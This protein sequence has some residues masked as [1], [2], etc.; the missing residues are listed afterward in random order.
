MI[1]V[2]AHNNASNGIVYIIDDEAEVRDA[3]KFLF[4][5]VHL[6]VETFSTAEQFLKANPVKVKA[7]VLVDVRLPGMGGIDLLEWLNGHEDRIPI[8]MMT[9]FGDIATALTA[10]KAGAKDFIVKPFNPQ[11]LLESVNRYLNDTSEF[12]NHSFADVDSRYDTLTPREHQ[13]LD[14]IYEGKLNKQ[15]A[16]ELSISLST[17]EAHRSALMGKMQVKTT[18]QL[19]KQHFVMEAER[20]RNSR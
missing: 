8:I 11:S 6:T 1:K 17:V 2:N 16:S 3:L 4:E 10:M 12:G 20:G 9:G 7:C 14:L 18:A 5:T 19:I 13:I 15:I